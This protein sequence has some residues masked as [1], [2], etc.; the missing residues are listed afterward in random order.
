MMHRILR[1]SAVALGITALTACSGN[2]NRAGTDSTAA[3]VADSQPG[4]NAPS[5]STDS[6]VRADSLQ[7][8]DTA[9]NMSMPTDGPNRNRKP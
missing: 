7:R 6:V 2:N 4:V 5:P 8:R 9:S 1:L 3:A